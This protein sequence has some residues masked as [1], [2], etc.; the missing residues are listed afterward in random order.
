MLV[1]SHGRHGPSYQPTDK[2]TY[3]PAPKLFAEMDGLSGSLDEDIAVTV[4]QGVVCVSYIK[5]TPDTKL[6]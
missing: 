1:L 4:N 2:E 3:V 5:F 6:R